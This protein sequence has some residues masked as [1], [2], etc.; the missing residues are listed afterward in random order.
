MRPGVSR[1]G[2]MRPGV[3]IIIPVYDSEKTLDLLVS[4][5]QSVFSPEDPNWEILMIDDRSSDN[6]WGNICGLSRQVPALRGIRLDKN[7]GQQNAICC[8]LSEARFDKSVTMDDDMQHAPS[9]IPALISC[10]ELGG[11]DVVYGISR[12]RHHN[13]YRNIGSRFLNF[14]FEKSLEKPVGIGISSFRALR[15]DLGKQIASAASGF[16][17]VSAATFR[18]TKKA[19][20]VKTGHSRRQFGKSNYSLRRLIAIVMNICLYYSNLPFIHRLRRRT[21]IFCIAERTP[22]RLLIAGAGACQLTAIKRARELGIS[23]VTADY[24]PN[25]PGKSICDFTDPAS[26][27]DFEGVLSAAMRYRIDGIFTLG[28]DQPIMTCAQVAEKLGLFSFL[29]PHE[30]ARLTD[31][32]LMK[33][34]LK[35]AAIPSVPFVYLNSEDCGSLPF[36]FPIVIKPLDSQGQRGVYK[37][38]DREE[39]KALFV[40]SLSYSRGSQLLAEAYYESCEITVSGWVE[41]GDLTIL[42]VTD[43]LTFEAPPVIGI[44]HGHHFPTKYLKSHGDEINALSRDVACAFNIKQGPVYI[45]M[46]IGSSGIVVNEVAGRLGGAHEDRL[47]PRVTGFDPL[48]WALN[49]VLDKSYD[50]GLLQKYDFRANPGYASM[51][52]F[53]ARPGTVVSL[54]SMELLM[55]QL[56]FVEF[57]QHH[58]KQG[59]IIPAIESAAGRA[60]YIFF[61]ADSED[62]LQSRRAAVYDKLEI[63]D[64]DG[65]NL[66]IK[67]PI[68]IGCP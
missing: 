65:R 15:T 37:C 9:E 33:E 17:Y 5:I 8:G 53:F 18:R 49:A 48:S 55:E 10:L 3:S 52:L 29:M 61:C 16:V 24:L 14:L 39:L 38:S 35:N 1:P 47:I 67:P 68:N 60:G 54:T 36:A 22:Q 12:E 28:T 42:T 62:Q 45:Q 34:T 6:S 40:K 56:P 26:T 2:V 32:R 27:F 19:G 41:C 20:N 31:K 25:A 13:W 23:V 30:A 43:R 59:S 64:A 58:L 51:E 7:Y 44:S 63:L 4:A 11:F 57:A 50:V 66:V 21:P 46:L